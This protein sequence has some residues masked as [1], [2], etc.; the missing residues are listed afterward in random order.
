MQLI[1]RLVM[2]YAPILLLALML[3]IPGCASMRTQTKQYVSILGSIQEEDYDKA[4]QT[5]KLA[6]ANG[7]YLEKDR[8]LYYLELGMVYHYAGYYDSSNT[9]LEQ[10]DQYM[11]D[12][13]T[14]SVSNIAASFLTN[15]NVLDYYG[16]DY[17]NIYVNVFKSLNYLHLNQFDA[18]F[19]EARRAYIKLGELDRKYGDYAR[20]MAEAEDMKTKAEYKPPVLYDDA[21]ARYLSLTLYRA[22][23]KPDDARID[24][25]KIS[26]LYSTLPKI[27][28][29][30]KPELIDSIA[31]RPAP[32][33]VMAFTGKAPEKYPVSLT[34]TTYK[35]WLHI[36]SSSGE[37]DKYWL[38]IPMPVEQGYHFKFELPEIKRTGTRVK[39]IVASVNDSTVGR[40]EKLE[41][42]QSVAYAT[43]ETRQSLIMLKTVTRAV[44]KGLAAAEA[45]KNIRKNQEAWVG[46]LTD[47]LA[48]AVVDATENAD[49]RAWRSMP[50][51]MWVGEFALEPGSYSLRLDYYDALR[52][53]IA[54]RVY[55]QTTVSAAGVNL[56]ESIVHQ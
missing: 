23:R 2:P 7:R 11:E 33:Q 34:I 40:L 24:R 26:E 47:A 19:V 9:A 41:D 21:L 44:V 6:R 45:K 10:A 27:Y 13:F 56:I 28:D 30:P 22:D 14:K 46:L 54:T 8:V 42:M 29:F 16:E 35:N 55:P 50:G 12:L 17:E 32:L 3:S 36:R 37:K 43:F 38:N 31:L 52:Q 48:D 5:V 25:D 18:A 1:Y 15:D 49:V 51:F 4:I 53:K 20:S 39:Y